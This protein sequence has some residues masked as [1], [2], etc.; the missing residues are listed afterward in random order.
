M[1]CVLFLYLLIS[2]NIKVW[3]SMRKIF[4]WH[5]D[6]TASGWTTAQ[7]RRAS[8]SHFWVSREYISKL[9][10][11]DKILPGSPHINSTR[12]YPST[13][14]IKSLAPSWNSTSP[15]WDL[16]ILSFIRI[17]AWTILL[18]WMKNTCRSKTFSKFKKTPQRAS[19]NNYPQT[20]NKS[21]Y[22]LSLKTH[23]NLLLW[24]KNK[25]NIK[26]KENCLANVYLHSEEK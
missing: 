9:S 8:K 25:Q 26:S 24:W 17:S 10:L 1:L 19:I 6:S 22:Q 2:H 13:S 16:S 15:W 23:L 7:Y 14:I 11:W 5:R 3:A 20:L 21:E 4:K 12:D 18:L